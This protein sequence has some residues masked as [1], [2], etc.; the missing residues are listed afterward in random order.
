MINSLSVVSARYWSEFDHALKGFM[1]VA[2]E[3]RA[4][5]AARRECN[6]GPVSVLTIATSPIARAVPAARTLRRRPVI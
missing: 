5:S 6:A 2:G 4:Y 3:V 1:G